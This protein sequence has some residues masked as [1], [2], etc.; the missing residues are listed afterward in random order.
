MDQ[1]IN[2]VVGKLTE[3]NE[4]KKTGRDQ[5]NMRWSTGSYAM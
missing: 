2:I 4:T 3:K 1:G 5:L